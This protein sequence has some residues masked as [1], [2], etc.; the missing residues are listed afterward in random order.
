MKWS[1]WESGVFGP[2]DA[3]EELGEGW[4]AEKVEGGRHR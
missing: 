4:I 3:F 2:V 1:A